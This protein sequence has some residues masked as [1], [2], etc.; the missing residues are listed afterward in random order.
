MFTW[1]PQQVGAAVPTDPFFAN[2]VLLIGATDVPGNTNFPDRSPS[3]SLVT[4]AAPVGVFES[5]AQA[6]YG[7]TSIRFDAAA[8]GSRL[9][10]AWPVAKSV[11]GADKLYTAEWSMYVPSGQSIFP[12]IHGPLIHNVFD[13]LGVSIAV[14]G[15][16]ASWSGAG[17][18][19]FNAW[20]KVAICRDGNTIRFFVA[21][22]LRSTIAFSSTYA[23]VVEE[24]LFIGR[25]TNG[26]SPLTG[27][28][29]EIRITKGVARYS[30]N[31]TPSNVRFPRS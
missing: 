29:D 12:A 20:N 24:T 11:T 25:A 28:L 31:Y 23:Q 4:N 27:W 21:G 14:G 1:G 8:A 22:V 30:A 13:T 18:W 6:L 5:T 10:V 2:V 17:I 7:S 15:S 26:T 9:N 3:P 19:A 16:S